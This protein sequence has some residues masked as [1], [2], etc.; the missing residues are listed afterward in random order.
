MTSLLH[1]CFSLLL[2]AGAVEAAEVSGRVALADSALKS[3]RAKRDYSGVVL[4]LEP[5]NGTAVAPAPQR[6]RMVQKNKAFLPH[7]LAVPVGSVVDF[8]NFDPIFHN[9]FS[10]YNGQIFDVGLYPPGTSRAVTFRRPGIARV[11]CNIH[12]AMSAVIAVMRTPWFAVTGGDGSFSM[13]GVPPGDYRLHV[14]HERATEGTLKALSRAVS[15]AGSVALGVI[16]VSET[17]YV[18][19]P[20]TNK[21]GQEYEHSGEDHLTYPGVRR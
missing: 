10:N 19:R 18:Q 3:V 2:I 16:P 1:T 5:L 9:A 6:A 12:P 11:F 8:P 4:W 20:H 15:V 17:G 21:Y 7:V 14:W 13:T